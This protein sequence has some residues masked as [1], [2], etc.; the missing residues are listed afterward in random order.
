MRI[1]TTL[2]VLLL[3]SPVFAETWVCSVV[4]RNGAI[5]TDQFRRTAN[6]FEK[7]S[8]Y[9]ENIFDFDIV[10]EDSKVIVLQRT[11]IGNIFTTVIE[12]IEKV[13]TRRYKSVFL[14]TDLLF[15]HSIDEGNCTVVE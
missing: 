3:A 15:T 13:G 10:H 2:L 5:L 12:Q 9:T 8:S 4:N 1:L 6:G 14:G 7:T 11:S